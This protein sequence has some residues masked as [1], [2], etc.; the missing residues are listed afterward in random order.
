M[1][2]RVEGWLVF[3]VLCLLFWGLWGFILKLAYSNLSWVETY[4]LSSLSS[5]ILVLFVVSYYG[6]KFPPLNTY[7]AL[8]FIAGFF[9]GAGY[10]FFVKAL[11]QGKASVVIPLTA[12]YPA[13]TAVIALVVLREK[14][15]V[16]Q[17]IGIILA[18]LASIL[19]SLK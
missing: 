4:F 19:L 12:L 6:L 11:E 13:I 8:A 7:S 9:G 16:Y 5:F 10:V 1:V 17:G 15:S 3:S 2:G 14:I 18:V